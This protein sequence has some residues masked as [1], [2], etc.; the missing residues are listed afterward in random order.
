[1]KKIEKK[2][3]VVVPILIDAIL[4]ARISNRMMDIL[5]AFNPK[6]TKHEFE[7]EM[8]YN[9]ICNAV[10][11]LKIKDENLDNILGAIFNDI[12]YGN[13]SKGIEE[14]TVIATELAKIIFTKWLE[15]IKKYNSSYK[16]AV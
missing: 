15:A 12:V 2:Q 9:G 13:R 14:S 6:V 1:M 4:F 3:C 11:I 8:Q 16:I 10:N 7:P 5:N